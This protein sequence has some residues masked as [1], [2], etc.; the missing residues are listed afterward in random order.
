MTPAERA[1]GMRMAIHARRM[2]EWA[3]RLRLT[4]GG[5]TAI[6]LIIV[7]G[8]VT[9]DLERRWAYAAL[10]TLVV[11]QAGVLTFFVHLGRHMK[12]LDAFNRRFL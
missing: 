10:Y 7:L 8:C 4:V 11:V 2:L 6:T 5:W 1:E 9:L 3:P 12:R